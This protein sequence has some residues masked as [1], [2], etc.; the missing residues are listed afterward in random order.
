MISLS[1]SLSLLS[2]CRSSPNGEG[3]FAFFAESAKDIAATITHRKEMRIQ[4][5]SAAALPPPQN[6]E[7]EE[8]TTKTSPRH[9]KLQNVMSDPVSP[10]S[11]TSLDF[12]PSSA[13]ERETQL[14]DRG[15][16]TSVRKCARR[17]R[18]IPTSHLIQ[19]AK[20][21]LKLQLGDGEGGEDETQQQKKG[22]PL[23]TPDEPTHVPTNE[24]AVQQ[25]MFKEWKRARN[26]KGTSKSLT[27]PGAMISPGSGTRQKLGT[28]ADR[29][30]TISTPTSERPTSNMSSLDGEYVTIHRESFF[31][32][33]EESDESTTSLGKFQ[34]LQRQSKVDLYSPNR[35]PQD[36]PQFIHSRPRTNAISNGSPALPSPPH[37]VP[38]SPVEKDR[39]TATE[40]RFQCD[41][42]TCWLQP[43]GPP[44][45][46]TQQKSGSDPQ[47]STRENDDLL[48]SAAYLKVIHPN[49]PPKKTQKKPKPT[50]RTRKPES[51]L[52]GSIFTMT[53]ATPTSSE[54]QGFNF[55]NPN[56]SLTRGLDVRSLLSSQRSLSESNLFASSTATNDSEDDDYVDMNH[57][58]KQWERGQL[59]VNYNELHPVRPREM[60]L[61][62]KTMR[63]QVSNSCGD[64]RTAA[65]VD[66]PQALYANAQCC[67]VLFGETENA[68]ENGRHVME[69]YMYGRASEGDDTEYPGASAKSGRGNVTAPCTYG[70]S[71]LG[72]TP[73]GSPLLTCQQRSVSLTDVRQAGGSGAQWTHGDQLEMTGMYV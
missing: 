67:S 14:R 62:R 35:D 45:S 5:R 25:E 28:P 26:Q 27:S 61:Q 73:S 9:Q 23:Y 72:S 22:T 37:H 43:R 17:S 59:Y 33:E 24:L 20:S 34:G 38:R 15:E 49:Q 2:V 65:M 54:G 58:Q 47:L 8:D 69:H 60:T 57:Y 12:T 16:Q 46:A 36:P 44:L 4:T 29:R 31:R 71:G 68:Y 52:P 32:E 1:L 55:P 3:G 7:E 30:S 66:E 42:S 56:H 13:S 41:G 18:V 39:T 70:D 21:Q 40:K 53:P 63:R 64:L 10:S 6:D 48:S 11:E 19:K 50:P 51:L